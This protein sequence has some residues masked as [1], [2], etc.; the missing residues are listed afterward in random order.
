MKLNG[1]LTALIFTLILFSLNG[2]SQE[3]GLRVILKLQS[4]ESLVLPGVN[5]ICTDQNT[6]IS[7]TKISVDTL[8]ND[9]LLNLNTTYI[10]EFKNPKYYN[11]S[12]EINTDVPRKFMDKIYLIEMEITMDFN[13]EQNPNFADIIY[14]PIGR[15]EF[16]RSKQKFDYDNNYSFKM[17]ARYT[18][19]KQKRC[20]LVHEKERTQ[21]RIEK[22]EE[23]AKEK[24][25]KEVLAQIEAE[26]LKIAELEAQLNLEI[27]T[28]KKESLDEATAIALEE[29]KKIEQKQLELDKRKKREEEELAE[30]LAEQKKQEELKNAPT[31]DEKQK[32]IFI[33][34][35]SAWASELAG[36]INDPEY[37]PKPIGTFTYD[38]TK[39]RNE[40]YVKD[41]EELRTKFPDQFNKAFKNWDYVYETQM[42]YKNSQKDNP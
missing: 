22:L 7:T 21:K 30:K 40:F 19:R 6:N 36:H 26:K 32:N 33:Y 4:K 18:D 17:S 31:F 11:K 13:C 10:I 34:P 2:F 20:A 35:A 3:S 8:T 15:I 24:E 25:D 39:S 16:N 23:K 5:I 1:L 29:Q 9:L 27:E 42:K 37:K 12:V 28:Q 41:V 14:K 38:I